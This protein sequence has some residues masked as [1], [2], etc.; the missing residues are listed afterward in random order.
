MTVLCMLLIFLVSA[1]S[2][3]RFLRFKFSIIDSFLL[4]FV[5]TQCLPY[6]LLFSEAFEISAE[7]VN[8]ACCELSLLIICISVLEVI[9]FYHLG[10]HVKVR[11]LRVSGGTRIFSRVIYVICWLLSIIYALICS[12]ELLTVASTTASLSNMTF[13]GSISK[14]GSLVILGSVQLGVLLVAFEDVVRKGRLTFQFIVAF[15]LGVPCWILSG[16]RS[17]L[18][19]PVVLLVLNNYRYKRTRRSQ[20]MVIIG[21]ILA[22]GVV[23][24]YTLTL[25]VGDWGSTILTAIRNVLVRDF[26]TLW[27]VSILLEYE[28]GSGLVLPYPGSG[29]VNA[30]LAFLPRSLFPAKGYRDTLWFTMWAAGLKGVPLGASTIGQM[31]W[32]YKISY[33]TELMLNFGAFGVFAMSPLYGL[34]LAYLEGLSTRKMVTYGPILWVVFNLWWLDLFAIVTGMGFVVLIVSL[35]GGS[36]IWCSKTSGCAYGGPAV[37]QVQESNIR[38]WE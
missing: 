33:V 32:G 29:Y 14:L 21:A 11:R 30:L 15:V 31:S 38:N 22:G 27:T 20:R 18:V 19:A 25:K 24:A 9:T 5:L 10:N 4:G 1:R 12:K 35:L 37:V 26:D 16:Q 23:L 6:I 13:R 17:A 7:P 3:S 2:I 34:L 36:G 28:V 8:R